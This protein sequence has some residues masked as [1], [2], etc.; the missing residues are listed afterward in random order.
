MTKHT[1]FICQ[2]CHCS[3]EKIPEKQYRDGNRLLE[4]LNNLANEK[5]SSAELEI[6][7][8]GCLWACS[9]GCVAAIS[10][11]EKLT[12]LIVDLP[13]DESAAALLDLMQLYINNDKGVFI[14]EKVP[15]LLQSKFFAQIPSVI[16]NS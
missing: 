9:R 3:S 14:W 12:Y 2:S 5:F 11:P 13:P 4:Q 8:V 16:C 10:C 6:K 1:L 15:K 7:P